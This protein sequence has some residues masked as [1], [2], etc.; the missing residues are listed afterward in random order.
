M[1]VK[2]N[3]VLVTLLNYMYCK[4]DLCVFLTSNADV[5]HGKIQNHH[6]SSGHSKINNNFITVRICGKSS[7]FTQ[8]GIN[9]QL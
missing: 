1:F 7:R 6:T 3:K 4:V 8:E 2:P 9:F 5:V